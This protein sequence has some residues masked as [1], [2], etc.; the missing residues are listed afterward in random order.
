MKSKKRAAIEAVFGLIGWD[1]EEGSFSY[2][3]QY[4]R[5][6]HRWQV[7]DA[8]DE[9]ITA[10][11]LD[12]IVSFLAGV[13]LGGKVHELFDMRLDEG[14]WT[15]PITLLADGKLDACI[16]LCGKLSVLE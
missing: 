14:D 7:S 13:A 4:N 16:A 3:Q 10:G 11:N 2:D 1:L 5:R 6:D 12:V 8:R 9:K 15:E